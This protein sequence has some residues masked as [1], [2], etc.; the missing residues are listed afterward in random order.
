MIKLFSVQWKALWVCKVFFV[1]EKFLL[2]EFSDRTQQ[3]AKHFLPFTSAYVHVMWHMGSPVFPSSNAIKHSSR[4]VGQRYAQVFCVGG[5]EGNGES[6]AVRS[7]SPSYPEMACHFRQAEEEGGTN[8]GLGEQWR[9]WKCLSL[10]ISDKQH[11]SNGWPCSSII[12]MLGK[13]A[14]TQTAV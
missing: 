2:S 9:S 8:A 4:K 13:T 10:F 3:P 14:K 1:N 5:E 6:L 7:K 11:C 12:E